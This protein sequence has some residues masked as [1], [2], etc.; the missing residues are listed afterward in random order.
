MKKDYQKFIYIPKADHGDRLEMWRTALKD[1]MHELNHNVNLELL[2]KLT[3]CWTLGS[4][5]ECVRRALKKHNKRLQEIVEEQEKPF[6]FE[7][8]AYFPV[9]QGGNTTERCP[10]VWL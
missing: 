9:P 2:C 7:P 3:D 10:K 4:I 6:E 5:K 1:H 8:V